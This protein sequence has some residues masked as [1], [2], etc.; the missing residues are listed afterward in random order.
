MYRL[1]CVLVRVPE[2]HAFRV[3]LIQFDNPLPCVRGQPLSMA[4]L[5]QEHAF[6]Q[7]VR[8]LIDLTDDFQ[9]QLQRVPI[10]EQNWKALVAGFTALECGFQQGLRTLAVVARKG[11]VPVHAA[12]N[13]ED[14]VPPCLIE[15]VWRFLE[16]WRVGVE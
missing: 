11:Q 10:R 1:S 16:N 14:S 13:E 5:N 6:P 8:V 7:R 12:A 4:L 9:I 3:D 2:C 15:V